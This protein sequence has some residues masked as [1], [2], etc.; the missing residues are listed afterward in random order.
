VNMTTRKGLRAHAVHVIDTQGH[1]VRRMLKD[2]VLSIS[3]ANL[4]LLGAWCRLL[5]DPDIHFL[6][7]TLPKWQDYAAL[8]CDTL[9]IG[10]LFFIVVTLLRRWRDGR[11]VPWAQSAFLLFAFVALNEA[12]VQ[13]VGP[14]IWFLRE[15]IG[16]VTTFILCAATGG[17]AIV[18]LVFWFQRAIRAVRMAVVVLAPFAL[19]NMAHASWH[20]AE[21]LIFAAPLKA[22]PL[23]AGSAKPTTRIVWIVFDEL[24][25]RAAFNERPQSVAMPE[26]DR[27]RAQSLFATHAC[28]PAPNTLYCFPS[29]IT[30]KTVSLVRKPNPSDLTLTFAGSDERVRWSTQPSIFGR[31]RGL[32]A[33][34]GLVGWH[35]PY[36]RIIGDDLDKCSWHTTRPEAENFNLGF[37]ASMLNFVWEIGSHI[38][39]LRGAQR[40]FIPIPTE[41][42]NYRVLYTKL[43]QRIQQEAITLATDPSLSLTLIHHSV[44]HLPG[45]Y[46]RTKKEFSLTSGDYFDNLELAD[47]TMGELRHAMEQA[48]MW[49]K[50]TVLVT[51]DH[52][53]RTHWLRTNPLCCATEIKFFSGKKDYRVPFILK[54]AGS[55]T[56]TVYPKRFNTILTHDLLLAI[57][58]GDIQGMQDLMPWID[59]HKTDP[60]A[61][62]VDRPNDDSI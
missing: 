40:Q 35:I 36:G 21:K 60:P 58:R 41:V 15:Q 61:E 16:T 5:Y 9:L 46:D 51:S 26:F 59:R 10:G 19:V 31:A 18:A 39:V 38:P 50:T 62:Y 8:L 25:Y 49:D 56:A 3:I 12:R 48:G 43:W 7:A 23:P 13:F 53:F 20:M 44:P 28:P 30:G 11:F 1:P 45:F 57:L 6:L 37:G 17:L 32:G 14:V 29:L 42:S 27:L 54:L 2:L 55:S 34:T 22:P 33:R 52:W 4:C 24:D 47:R